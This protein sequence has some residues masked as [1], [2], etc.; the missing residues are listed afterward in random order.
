MVIDNPKLEI[1]IENLKINL[2]NLSLK[3]MNDEDRL[4]IFQLNEILSNI[5]SQKEYEKMIE[6]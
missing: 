5:T 4:L 1:I 2:K 3:N 6:N